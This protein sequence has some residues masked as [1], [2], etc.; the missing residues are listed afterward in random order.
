MREEKLRFLV[1]VG[2]PM[3]CEVAEAVP[4]A[5]RLSE[6]SLHVS[7]EDGTAIDSCESICLGFFSA[8]ANAF[9][10]VGERVNLFDG[11]LG[12]N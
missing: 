8:T 3:T 11:S 1:G 4:D 6:L 12:I 7:Q 10:C 5:T 9:Y 2:V